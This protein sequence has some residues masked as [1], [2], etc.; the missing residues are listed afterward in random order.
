V[1]KKYPIFFCIFAVRKASTMTT[2]QMKKLMRYGFFLMSFIIA[3]GLAF[4]SKG[5]DNKNKKRNANLKSDFVPIRITSPSLLKNGFTYSGSRM[6]SIQKE[7]SSFSLNSL[8][9][10]QKGNIT[11]IQP[12]RYK[13][14]ITGLNIT[15]AT[16]NLQLLD[17]KIPMHK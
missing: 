7:N 6:L 15:P 14:N 5:G 11:F 4:G 12:Y 13:V 9:T 10:Y 8:V 1:V 16:S 17:V 2:L 3:V